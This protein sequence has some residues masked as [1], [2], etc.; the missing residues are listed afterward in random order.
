MTLP[1]HISRASKSLSEDAPTKAHERML[2]TVW[3]DQTFE[4]IQ[5]NLKSLTSS[6]DVQL[7]INMAK[8]AN[9]VIE[10]GGTVPE[11]PL[12]V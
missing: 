8:I 12:H 11:H 6:R 2:A 7:D 1:S 3:C 9:E 4:R 5:Q 10:Q